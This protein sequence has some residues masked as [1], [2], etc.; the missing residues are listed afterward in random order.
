M[1]LKE[2]KETA[3]T[4]SLCKGSE[5]STLKASRSKSYIFFPDSY[6]SNLGEHSFP[7][8]NHTSQD[9]LCK[10]VEKYMSEHWLTAFSW[11]D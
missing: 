8:V 6:Q 4:W 10:H 7:N 5:A 9:K 2:T 11:A 3:N 1:K